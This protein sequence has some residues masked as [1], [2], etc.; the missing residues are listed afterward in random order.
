MGQKSLIENAK[1]VAE[2]QTILYATCNVDGWDQNLNQKDFEELANIYIWELS[3][4][5]RRLLSKSKKMAKKKKMIQEALVTVDSHHRFLQEKIKSYTT[6]Y[7]NV[8]QGG[9]GDIIHENTK[10]R[11]AKKNKAR[12]K[13]F[14]YKELKDL[15][16]IDDIQG[17]D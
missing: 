16:V 10:K 1:R 13:I 9:G 15:Q 17:T 8:L 3:E 14:K 11:K 4:Q 12:L 5:C 2:L 6:V 7:Q